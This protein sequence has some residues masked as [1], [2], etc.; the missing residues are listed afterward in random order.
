MGEPGGLP[1]MGSQSWTRL[2]RLSK[3]ASKQG[4]NDLP[5]V[6]CM[7]N[8][9]FESRQFDSRNVFSNMIAKSHVWF[10]FLFFYLNC[11]F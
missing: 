6:I 9:E 8:A 10:Y 4:L 3:Q 5:K 1:S 2:K 11:L 7:G